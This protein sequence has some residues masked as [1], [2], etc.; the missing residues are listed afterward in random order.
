[1]RLYYAIPFTLTCMTRA[2]SFTPFLL[3]PKAL[4][5]VNPH[6][7]TVAT[8]TGHVIRAFGPAYT[9][10]T[11]FINEETPII[12]ICFC[13]ICIQGVMDNGPA[14]QANFARDI[15]QGLYCV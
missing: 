8:L 4:E 11:V 2:T 10:S 15:Q 1:M 6:I 14:K 9:V 12:F 5:A 7:M 13:C 3:L